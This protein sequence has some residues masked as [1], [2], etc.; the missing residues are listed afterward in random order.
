M[1]SHSINVCLITKLYDKHVSV[2]DLEMIKG[3]KG[4]ANNEYLYIPII[5][6]TMH[7]ANLKERLASCV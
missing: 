3:I 7:E 1:H 2:I 5:E 6:N 4:H